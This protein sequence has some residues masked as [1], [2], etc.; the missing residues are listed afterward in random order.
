[1]ANVENI[2][3]PTCFYHGN[4]FGNYQFAMAKTLCHG[5][6]TWPI[7]VLLYFPGPSGSLMPALLSVEN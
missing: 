2:A 4:Y 3:I 1:M 7:S 5:I 6:S